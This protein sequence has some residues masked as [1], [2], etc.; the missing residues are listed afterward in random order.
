MFLRDTYAELEEVKLE[1]ED[2]GGGNDGDLSNLQGTWSSSGSRGK[3]KTKRR[4][5]VTSV[6]L[7]IVMDGKWKEKICFF[8]SS[9]G[10]ARWDS[11]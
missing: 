10:S 4:N 1:K 7:W 3:E 2:W 9:K 5:Y 6:W 8:V 11:I